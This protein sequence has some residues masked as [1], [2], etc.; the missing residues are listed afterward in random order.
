MQMASLGGGRAAPSLA[1]RS[2]SSLPGMLRW[3]GTQRMRTDLG[4]V[5]GLRT[6]EG[7]LR[8]TL[9]N[10]VKTAYKEPV[11]GARSRI[12]TS[13]LSRKIHRSVASVA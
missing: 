6:R 8:A 13:K 7:H 2:A 10:L 3:P 5:W 9:Q 11:K 12:A 4:A 1:A